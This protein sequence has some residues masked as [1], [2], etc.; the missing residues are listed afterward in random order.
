MEHNFESEFPERESGLSPEEAAAL[1]AE[2]K[3]KLRFA[4]DRIGW[5]TAVLIAVWIAVLNCVRAACIL[6]DGVGVSGPAAAF[7]NKYMLIL[8][9]AGLAVAMAVA[10]VILLSVPKTKIEGDPASAKSFLKILLMCYGASYVGNLIGSALLSVWNLFT[11]N[12]VG[13]ELVT[14]LYDMDPLIM[15]VS[16]GVLAPILEELFFRKLLTDR[17]R[18]FGEVT[19]ILLPALLFALFH[20]SA[21]QFVYAFAVGVLLGYFYCRTGNYWLSVL[22]HSV[23]NTVSGMISV[24]FLPHLNAFYSELEA[25]MQG[26]PEGGA[27]AELGPLTEALLPLLSEYGVVLGLYALYTLLVFAVNITGVILLAV[28]FKKFR[29]RKGEHSLSLRESAKAVFRAPGMIVCI[30]L[31]VALTVLSLFG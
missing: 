24:L 5:T 18:A 2:S 4:A 29:E 9:E 21:S 7:Y 16:V 11:G 8:N 20:M 1:C 27:D 17:L 10:A 6:I 3:K 25:V 30:L 23:F 13:D 15:F 28:N 22:I 26:F 12:S 14:L 19:A 31:T